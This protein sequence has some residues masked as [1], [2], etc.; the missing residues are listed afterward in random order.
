[1]RRLFAAGRI[2]ARHMA[3]T[4]PTYTEIMAAVSRY[5]SLR[6]AGAPIEVTERAYTKVSRMVLD[7][8]Y[9]KAD[10]AG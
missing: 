4:D 3:S 1:M 9:P 6:A 5:G 2:P 7:A 8:L 10:R